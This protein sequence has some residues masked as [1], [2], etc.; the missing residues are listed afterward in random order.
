MTANRHARV[1][2]LF[3]AAIELPPHE[4]GPW[5]ATACA[6]DLSLRREVEA[7]LAQQSAEF[8]KPARPATPSTGNWRRADAVVNLDARNSED[9]RAILIRNKPSH[10]PVEEQERPP[11]TMIADRYRIV[12]QW[13]VGGMVVVYRADDVT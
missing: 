5:L 6:D 7:L 9:S 12:S 11:G 8:S 2:Q 10:N 13:G 1:K 4:R 3:L